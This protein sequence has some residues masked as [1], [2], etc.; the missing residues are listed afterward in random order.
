MLTHSSLHPAARRRATGALAT[1]LHAV[2]LVAALAFG[3]HALAS[4][5]PETVSAS[6][7][8]SALT[9]PADA[10]DIR[11]VVFRDYNANGL[12]DSGPVTDSI[13]IDIGLA[14]VELAAH[15]A[16]NLQAASA[17]TDASGA[18]TL[19]GLAAGTHYRV[20]LSVVPAGL[21]PTSFNVSSISQQANGTSVQFTTGGS[22]GVSFGLNEPCEYCQPGAS[23]AVVSQRRLDDGSLPE[24]IGIAAWDAGLET[25]RPFYDG[26]QPSVLDGA[27]QPLMRAI[28]VPVSAVGTLFGL[29]YDR[30]ARRLYSSAYFKRYLP[31]GPGGTG[32]I[33]VSDPN[34]GAA[35]LFADLNG[36]F[37]PNTAGPDAHGPTGDVRSDYVVLAGHPFTNTFDAVGKTSLGDID[38]SEDGRTLFVMNLY[39]RR[40]YALPTDRGPLLDP[41]SAAHVLSFTVPLGALFVPRLESNCDANDARPFGLKYFRG[42]LY[43][44]VV[45]SGQSRPPS[46]DVFDVNS[47]LD[48]DGTFNVISDTFSD[49]DGNGVFNWQHE[50]GLAAFV[51][52]ANPATGMFEDPPVIT[53][54]LDF[55]DVSAADRNF[56][57]WAAVPRGYN[58]DG[59]RRSYAQPMLTDIEFDS[60]N[61]VIGIRD[62]YGDQTA[63]GTWFLEGNGAPNSATYLGD[64]RAHGQLLR[65]CGAPETGWVMENGGNCGGIQAEDLGY[66]NAGPGGRRFYQD[67]S[68]DSAFYANAGGLAI[69]PGVALISTVLDPAGFTNHG[70]RWYRN[71]TG[72]ILRSYNFYPNVPRIGHPEPIAG[73][74]NGM[75]DVELLCDPAPV[76]IGNRLWIDANRNGVQDPGEAPLAGITVTLTLAD[77]SAASTVTNAD[78]GYYFSSSALL[79]RNRAGFAQAALSALLQAQA[80]TLSVDLMQPVMTGYAVAPANAGGVR[81]NG[82][83][84]DV[85]DNDAVL[86]GAQAI[87]TGMLGG[88][89]ASNHGLD[90]GFY[91]ASGL[92]LDKTAL[93]P[94]TIA[95]G[96]RIDYR[97][98]VRNTSAA[99]VV[100]VVVS[101]ALPAGTTYISGSAA[102]SATL[103]GGVLTWPARDLAPN[104]WL[105][106]TLALSV[107]VDIGAAT[108]IT[109]VALL[110]YG[111]QTTTISSNPTRTPL[112]PTAVT[113]DGFD[114][115]AEQGAIVLRWRT[116]FEADSY[117]FNILRA[118]ANDR[119]AATRI[120]AEPIPARGMGAEYMYVDAQGAS[121]AFYWL[122]EIGLSGQRQDH[123]PVRVAA[124]GPV[125]LLQQVGGVMLAQQNVPALAQQAALAQL[126]GMA[127]HV[128]AGNADVLPIAEL[129]VP[130][131]AAPGASPVLPDVQTPSDGDRRQTA[132]DHEQSRSGQA[133][134]GARDARDG[135]RTVQIVAANV[136]ASTRAAVQAV[137]RAPV[138]VL[139]GARD[140]SQARNAVAHAAAHVALAR[141]TQMHSA[142][143]G[144]ATGA[145][146]ATAAAIAAAGALIVRRRRV[147][148]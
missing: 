79:E 68:G 5:A 55:R 120:T 6:A 33:Y 85:R 74:G 90:F 108:A 65:A 47:S 69:H 27:D 86:L 110:S 58:N 125:S 133:A 50:S 43:V 11:G 25:K 42:Q 123:G 37:G 31:M 132:V 136:R 98:V 16:N 112:R 81:S 60:G 26:G 38:L 94:G 109:N 117:G 141:Q 19:T 52:R 93:T 131:T 116:A 40:I 4:A 82:A 101:D 46:G 48:R 17:Q 23:L 28:T 51:L 99:S 71:D 64:S 91:P 105:T 18:Y 121:G 135:D 24:A 96:D 137:V 61:M 119:S 114:A 30:V 10:G 14:G 139:R 111:A 113:L 127:Q 147:Q 103:Q 12:M 138:T 129:L 29:A 57:S 63:L 92:E 15:D 104:A 145:V 83:F 35:T 49:G 78:G 143:A 84:D 97:I 9:T 2:V 41:A 124:P 144:V 89:G 88:P 45:C 62:R 100:G 67:V 75:G 1:V 73:K 70:V 130:Q 22:T 53:Q 134:P 7:E 115:R 76:Q 3:P 77:G 95:A 87:I 39:D 102:P 20:E 34:T 148:R 126:S 13:A 44:G 59:T 118:A 66:S 107:N 146:V 122:E 128:V 36:I 140:E 106:L 8:A 80:Y 142:A 72:S 21:Q 54:D 56:H 32:A